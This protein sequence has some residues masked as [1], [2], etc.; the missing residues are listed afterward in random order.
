MKM[1]S[2][3]STKKSVLSIV[4]KAMLLLQPMFSIVVPLELDGA[5]KFT[6]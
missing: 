4:K 2:E 6:I 3:A 1:Q 5:P